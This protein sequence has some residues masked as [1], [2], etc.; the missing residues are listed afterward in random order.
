MQ[1]G[2]AKRLLSHIFAHQY[3]IYLLQDQ[4]NYERFG[5]TFLKCPIIRVQN[6]LLNRNIMYKH[7]IYECLPDLQTFNAAPIIPDIYK[8][9]NCYSHVT[10]IYMPKVVF[11]Q[12]NT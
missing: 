2:N 6:Y 9:P 4:Q 12:S 10:L 8:Y 7:Y 3:T 5:T 11:L 1:S